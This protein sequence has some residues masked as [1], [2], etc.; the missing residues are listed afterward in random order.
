MSLLHYVYIYIY[1]YIYICKDFRRNIALSLP[2]ADIVIQ[3]KT[4]RV[5]NLFCGQNAEL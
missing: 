1:I 2:S 3:N 5:L 4:C